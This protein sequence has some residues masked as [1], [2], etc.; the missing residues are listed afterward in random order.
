T[1]LLTLLA[2]AC[3]VSTISAQTVEVPFEFVHNQ[4]V[5]KVTIDGKGPFNAMVDTG[6]DPSAVDLATARQIGIKLDDK[7]HKGSGGGTDVNLSYLCKFTS[8]GVG[9]ITANNVWAAAIDLTKVSDKMGI[10]IDAIL[11]QSVLNKR[12]VQ[13][14]YPHGVLRFLDA[15]PTTA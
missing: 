13:F 3:F 1:I 10:H 11:G 9:T 2:I 7:G 4:V 14:D 8:L 15:S 6:T 12:I 5:I